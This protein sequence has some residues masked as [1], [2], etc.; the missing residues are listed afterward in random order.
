MSLIFSV[1]LSVS[2]VCCV[3]VYMSICQSVCLPVCL[4]NGIWGCLCSFHF[5]V[6]LFLIK[7]SCVF[8]DFFFTVVCVYV[9]VCLLLGVSVGCVFL[10]PIL[11]LSSCCST[12]VYV[13][14]RKFVGVA[15]CIFFSMSVFLSDSCFVYFVPFF[16]CQ[17]A[18]LF[19]YFS[20]SVCFYDCFPLSCLLS[21]FFFLCNFPLFFNY[22]FFIL[23]S[24][25]FLFL[26]LFLFHNL[27]VS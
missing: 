16:V 22:S 15:A 12:C 2:G 11:C 1:C 3:G 24:F 10:L 18:C 17:S 8:S 4:A 25:I 23:P 27:S 5:C 7:F 20:T 13:C 6:C 21:H 9:F 14:V 26:V 19:V